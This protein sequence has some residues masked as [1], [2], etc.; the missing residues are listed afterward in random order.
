MTHRL[1]NLAGTSKNEKPGFT[2]IEL[3]VVIAIISILASLLLPALI[4]AR[5][6]A[7]SI[8]CMNNLKQ[9]GSAAMLY[10]ND[11]ND[12]ILPINPVP[13][14]VGNNSQ[15]W[16]NLL[17]KYVP[18]PSWGASVWGQSGRTYGYAIGGIY[19]CPKVPN[20]EPIFWGGGYGVCETHISNYANTIKFGSLTR[21][22]SLYLF[23]DADNFNVGGTFI[24][25][26]CPVE[27]PW[28]GNGA[29]G[30]PRHK[31]K[32]N[33]CFMDGHVESMQFKILATPANPSNPSTDFF[34]HYSY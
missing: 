7:K 24:T 31:G 4:N 23:G 22:S 6:S 17:D 20:Y 3:L 1:G 28:V 15:W 21:P 32:V 10:A 9:L 5:E 16:A 29:Q 13:W 34:G 30:A 2:L 12:A 26:E 33:V 19:Q 14:P 27:W 11:N 25:V 18:V 8:Q